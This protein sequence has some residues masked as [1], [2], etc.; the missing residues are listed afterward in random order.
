MTVPLVILAVLSV[1][2]GY[3][4]FPTGAFSAYLSPVF[5]RYVREGV[6]HP[7]LD[8]AYWTTA[9]ITFMAIVIGSAL[10][11]IVYGQSGP[12]ASRLTYQLIGVWKLFINDYYVEA[13]YERVIVRGLRDGL[14]N[15][16]ARCEIAIDAGVSGVGNAARGIASVTS[17]AQTG[18]VRTYALVFLVGAVAV[19]A[20]L[21]TWGRG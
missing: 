4:Q 21:L 18:F 5:E 8:A 10:A 11:Y 14:G 13:S 2:A 12:L 1:V 17:T 16:I 19:L 7:T 15:L 6:H 3:A 9:G 20:Y